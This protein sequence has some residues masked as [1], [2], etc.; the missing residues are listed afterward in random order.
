VGNGRSDGGDDDD[1]GLMMIW[2]DVAD[3]V[4]RYSRVYLVRRRLP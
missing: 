2:G 3:S 1:D 4:I